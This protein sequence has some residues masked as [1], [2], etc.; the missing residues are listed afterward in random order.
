MHFSGGTRPSISSP[1]DIVKSHLHTLVRAITDTD[2]LANDV[3]LANLISDS[4]RSRL[5]CTS[6]LS[7]YEKSSI[8]LEEFLRYLSIFNDHQ[9]LTSFCHVLNT[10]DDPVLSRLSEKLS[11]PQEVYVLFSGRAALVIIV[12]SSLL[13]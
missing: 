3:F 13:L 6:G 1:H 7:P 10:Q 2:R 4:V 12:R 5:L 11:V 9:I 8:L